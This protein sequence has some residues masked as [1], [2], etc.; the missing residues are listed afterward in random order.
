MPAQEP[1][2]ADPV[3]G[4][5]DHERMDAT[6]RSGPLKRLGVARVVHG[7]VGLP[8]RPPEPVEDDGDLFVLVGVDPDDDMGT[9]ERDAGYDGWPP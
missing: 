9:T 5:L 6:E 3:A 8:E 7:D 2:D 4:A 1:G